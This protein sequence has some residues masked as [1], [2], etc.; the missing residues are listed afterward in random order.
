MI[1]GKRLIDQQVG[2]FFGCAQVR[3]DVDLDVWR[4]NAN[5]PDLLG[6]IGKYMPSCSKE[7]GQHHDINGAISDLLP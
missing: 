3:C 4:F 5:L 1:G 2:N 7:I 6:N